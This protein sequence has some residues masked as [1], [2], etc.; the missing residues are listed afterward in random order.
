[1][2]DTTEVHLKASDLV[3]YLTI[4][5]KQRK[6][7]VQNFQDQYGLNHSVTQTTAAEM[8]DLLKEINRLS[9]LPTPIEQAI[10]KDKK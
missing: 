4:A 6:R 5:Y 8:N 10:N 3:T 1:M 7:A 2:T 9:T